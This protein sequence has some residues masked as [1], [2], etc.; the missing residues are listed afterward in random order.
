M[1]IVLEVLY[2]ASIGAFAAL[3]LG[4]AAACGKLERQP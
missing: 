4:L 2:L 3:V 1:D